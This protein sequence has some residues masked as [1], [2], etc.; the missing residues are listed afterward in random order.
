MLSEWGL[1][2]EAESETPQAL[3]GRVTDEDV[4]LRGE[5]A[6]VRARGDGVLDHSNG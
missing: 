5:Q 1:I 2:G 6:Y 3:V 4:G